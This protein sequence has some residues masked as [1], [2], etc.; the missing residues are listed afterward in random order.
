MMW[1]F[2]MIV[3]VLYTNECNNRCPE[4]TRRQVFLT[5]L[6]H[7]LVELFVELAEMVKVPRKLNIFS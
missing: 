1:V 5:R 7:F 4:N 2:Y 6:I 3:E